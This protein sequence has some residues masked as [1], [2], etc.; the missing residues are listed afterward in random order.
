MADR[1][2]ASLDTLV[3]GGTAV[4]QGVRVRRGS[5]LGFEVGGG[6]ELLDAVAAARRIGALAKCRPV[7]VEVC[8]RCGGDGRGRR[9]RGSCGLCHGPGIQV[10]VPLVGWREATPAEV[11]VGV[12]QALAALRG[13]RAPRARESLLALLEE[14]LPAAPAE[15]R[16]RAAGE[17][18]ALGLGAGAAAPG[19]GSQGPCA[20]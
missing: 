11:A 15:L 17:L 6:G 13:A 4:I 16:G 19:G 20:A 18:Q 5:L 8:S 1:I 7:R 10:T 14:V 3:L 2:A 12:E 9:D